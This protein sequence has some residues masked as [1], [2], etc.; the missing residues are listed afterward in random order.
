MN[1]DAIYTRNTRDKNPESAPNQPHGIVK[2]VYAAVGCAS[3][4]LGTIGIFLPF[5]PTTVFYLCTL[6]CFAK[7]SVR[8]N[9]WFTSTKLYRKHLESFAKR[10][11][12]TL[13][14]KITSILMLTLLMGF[15]IYMM[16]G[17]T[18]TGCVALGCVW[19]FHVLYFSV[20]IKTE[21]TQ[22]AEIK[23]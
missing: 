10:R 3:L 4:V 15:G 14:T 7:S 11:T 16:W 23:E 20:G 22:T 6:Y 13:Q 17:K 19:L 1:D 5:L 9:L 21:K 2:W 12:L 18:A 8:L